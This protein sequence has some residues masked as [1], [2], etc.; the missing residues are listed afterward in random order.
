MSNQSF[1]IA[2]IISIFF[3]LWMVPTFLFPFDVREYQLNDEKPALSAR[4]TFFH[5]DSFTQSTEE[6]IDVSLPEDGELSDNISIEDIATGKKKNLIENVKEETDQ[7]FEDSLPISKEM[8]NQDEVIEK[9]INETIKEEDS[10]EAKQETTV[11][12]EKED[13]KPF[14]PASDSEPDNAHAQNNEKA[15]LFSLQSE[16]SKKEQKDES[17]HSVEGELP[18]DLTKSDFLDDRI[19]PP[20]I[21]SFSSPDYPEHLRKRKIEGRV[22]LKVLIDKEGKAIQVEI[23]K[24]SGY[25]AFDQV[26]MQSVYQWQFKPA[27]IGKSN[28][29]SWVLLPIVFR[30]K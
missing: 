13:L 28:K 14:Q 2:L 29:E 19:I 20:K 10:I 12:S 9:E 24:T 3:H 8:K 27:Q 17:D 21:V 22:Q 26:A 7:R 1:V 6:G 15:Q 30:L 4:I 16:G 11:L 23:E 25:Q 5:S 18:L